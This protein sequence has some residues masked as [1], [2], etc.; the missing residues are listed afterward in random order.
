MSAIEPN[1][2]SLLWFT[3]LWTIC[4]VGFLVLSGSFPLNAARERG[5]ASSA[6]LALCNAALMAVLAV[7]TLT[8]GFLELRVTTLIVVAGLVFLFAPTPFE[9]WPEKWRDGRVVLAALLVMQ[10]AGLAAVYALTE[11]HLLPHLT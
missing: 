8:F 7:L 10:G 9:V 3:L 11:G 1:I 6:L 5:R 2:P 4:C